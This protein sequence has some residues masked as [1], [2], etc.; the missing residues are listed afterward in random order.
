MFI[1]ILFHDNNYSASSMSNL[2][3]N[4]LL[5]SHNSTHRNT[6]ESLERTVRWERREMHPPDNQDIKFRDL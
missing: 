3:L 1:H 6:F 5:Y 2:K 4:D